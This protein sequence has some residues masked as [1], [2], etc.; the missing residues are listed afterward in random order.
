MNDCGTEQ[1]IT[2]ETAVND[3]E[4]VSSLAERVLGRV[5]A[6]DIFRPGT[7]DML[8]AKGELIDEISL[9]KTYRE[10]NPSK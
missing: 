2:A 5:A 4:V 10:K 8:V 7:E 9:E 1:S 6:E 3:G